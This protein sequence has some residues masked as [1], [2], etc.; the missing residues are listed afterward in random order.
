MLRELSVWLAKLLA[1]GQ[2]SSDD[3][4]AAAAL[5]ERFA[6]THFEVGLIHGDWCGE[7]LVRDSSGQVWSIDSEEIA[8]GAYA[9]DLARAWSRWQLPSAVWRQFLSGYAAGGGK[10]ISATGFPFWAVIATSAGAYF[11]LQRGRGG[12]AARLRRQ[13]MLV[14]AIEEGM[15]PSTA[16]VS[17]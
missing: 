7:N 17:L 1:A 5:A 10:E 9:Y 6:P 15:T 2:L 4:A 16:L 3:A 14:Q 12:I 11:R 8:V 13:R